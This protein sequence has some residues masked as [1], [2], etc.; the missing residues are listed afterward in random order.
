MDTY[1]MFLFFQLMKTLRRIDELLSTIDL[2]DFCAESDDDSASED[3]VS[4]DMDAYLT[5]TECKQLIRHVVDLCD[6]IAAEE[7]K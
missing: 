1:S 3:T 4:T 6:V 5:L 2:D 7:E